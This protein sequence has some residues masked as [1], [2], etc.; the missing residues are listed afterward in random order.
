[1]L[2]AAKFK[3]RKILEGHR[4]AIDPLENVW[5]LSVFILLKR[6]TKYNL[7][8]CFRILI[9]A[10]GYRRCDGKVNRRK[11]A[12]EHDAVT[13]TFRVLARTGEGSLR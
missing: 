12:D 13:L 3:F 11:L 8:G 6:R 10:F 5:E 7:I 4:Q 2:K 9:P 1:L